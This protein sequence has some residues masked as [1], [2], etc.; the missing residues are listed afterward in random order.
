MKVHW[1]EGVMNKRAFE[2]RAL[3]KV[4]LNNW[5][6]KVLR[7]ICMG[8]ITHYHCNSLLGVALQEV[9]DEELVSHDITCKTAKNPS[10]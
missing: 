4:T 9:C 8:H 3:S 6:H 5:S 7:K 10:K 1:R 2:Q